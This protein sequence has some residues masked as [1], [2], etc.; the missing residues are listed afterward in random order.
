MVVTQATAVCCIVPLVRKLSGLTV[1]P[2]EPGHGPDPQPTPFVLVSEENL[3]EADTTGV[4]G[5]V[6]VV[7]ETL[8]L[9]VEFIE[10]TYLRPNPNIA[11]AVDVNALRF[12]VT[13]AVRIEGIVSIMHEARRRRAL[14]V[15][16]KFVEP[17][18]CGNPK[19]TGVIHRDAGDRV[20]AEA[21]W[22][23]GVVHITGKAPRLAIERVES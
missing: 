14:S 5:I 19:R 8:C 3:T 2:R 16:R 15:R 18:F 4:R 1:E 20:V 6:P 12:V 10:T 17:T 13:Q 23:V 7:C 21:I 9:R 22:I 11:V